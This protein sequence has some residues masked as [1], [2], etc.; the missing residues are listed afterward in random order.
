[1]Y[2]DE[3]NMLENSRLLHIKVPSHIL[4]ALPNISQQF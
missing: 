4:Y 2:V 3:S 1:M